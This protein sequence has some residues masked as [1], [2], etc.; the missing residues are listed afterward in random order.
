M[1]KNMPFF[2]TIHLDKMLKF[3]MFL[4]KV[5]SPPSHL[6]LKLVAPRCPS[7]PKSEF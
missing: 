6:L 7:A 2:L 1:R 4:Q 5:N 3:K